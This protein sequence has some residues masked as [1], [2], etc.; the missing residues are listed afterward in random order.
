MTQIISGPGVG[1][2]VPQALYPPSLQVPNAPY[3][4]ATNEFTLAPGQALPIPAGSW[5][6]TLG[7]YSVLQWLDPVTTTWRII[8]T[9]REGPQF[10]ISDGFTR[11]VA[12]LTGCPV[13]AVVTAQ[14]NGSYVQSTTT[15]T[16]NLGNSTWQ[17]VV[18]GAI[19]SISISVAGA[20][21]GMAPLCFIPAP[22]APGVQATAA[23][24][25]SG[26][27]ISTITLINAGAGYQTTPTMSILPNPADPNWAAGSITTHATA[28]LTVGLP[29]SI[30]AVLCTNSG[31]A[32]SALPTLT[33]A[34]AGANATVI[35]VWMSTITSTSI[36]AAGAA[37]PSISG[38]LTTTLGRTAAVDATT[39]PAI[40]LTNFIT[41]P[42]R[43]EVGFGGG[44]ASLVT[45]E[46]SGLFTGVPTSLVIPQGT[47]ATQVQASLATI[48][49][50]QGSANDTVLMQQ[51]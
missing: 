4:E 46:D 13:A 51:L 43:A 16:P 11:R 1:L 5:M 14:G 30:T 42:L 20:G 25:I 28:G 31:V 6:I 45:I 15:V 29:G 38:L 26:G 3:Q 44:T 34:G 7:K 36:S 49:L 37:Y 47:N 22:K 10:V 12:N 50:T 32:L 48:V 21:Y 8:E 17:P 35:P 18:G 24:T 27:S 23:A 9:A 19:T 33:V 41:R 40:S 2:P 39:N